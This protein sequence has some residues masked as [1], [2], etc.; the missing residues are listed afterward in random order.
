MMHCIA[1]MYLAAIG[2][3]IVQGGL[4]GLQQAEGCGV[5]RVVPQVCTEASPIVMWELVKL[6][7]TAE[8]V[9]KVDLNNKVVCCQ[10][11]LA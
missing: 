10:V 8:L 11:I 1:Y 5:F 4:V 6:L 3:E 2:W 9:K 7:P